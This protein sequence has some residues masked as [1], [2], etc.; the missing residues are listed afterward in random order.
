VSKSLFDALKRPN[1]ACGM[2][3]FDPSMRPKENP[4]GF[5]L[6]IFPSEP[7]NP[8]VYQSSQK[9]CGSRLFAFNT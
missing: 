9:A 8:E 6:E 2:L 4:D 3:H 1:A 7:D 5:L